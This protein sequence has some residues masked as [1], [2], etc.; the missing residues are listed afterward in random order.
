MSHASSIDVRGSLRTPTADGESVVTLKAER[1]DP[2]MPGCLPQPPALAGYHIVTDA[3]QIPA[4][5]DGHL[6]NYLL[7]GNGLFLHAQRRE[8]TVLLRIAPAQVRGLP[9]LRSR[10][11]VRFPLV[12]AHLVREMVRVAA[13][14]ARDRSGSLE[15]LLYLTFQEGRWQLTRPPQE[16]TLSSVQLAPDAD[17]AAVLEALID[18][19]SHPFPLRAFSGTDHESDRGVF[20]FAVLI[21]DSA[22]TPSLHARLCVYGVFLEV[23]PSLLFELPDELGGTDA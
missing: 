3:A 13:D 20:R 15:V 19:H 12:P 4:I 14:A 1:V 5:A 7:A 18:V 16:Q 6:Y 2:P 21:A 17:R 22:G 10:L 8:L 9:A 23:P 11:R